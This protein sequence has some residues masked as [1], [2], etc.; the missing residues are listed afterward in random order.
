MKKKLAAP[1]ALA[2]ALAAA[3][4]AFGQG[5]YVG[6]GVGQG[7]VDFGAV[8]AGVTM[9]DKDTTATVRLGYQFHRSLAVE[10]GYYHL[11]DY[12]LAARVGGADISA[13]AEARSVGIAL[14]GTVPLNRFDL[15]GRV[16]YARSELKATGSALGFS[17]SERDRENEWFAGIG[18]RFHVS[19]EVGVFAEWQ[20]H[21]KLELDTFF[22]GVDVRF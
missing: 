20:R 14:V 5:W 10:I 13:G 8:P 3:A 4:P 6:A 17:A 15:Y 19:R 21:D 16:G 1:L 11:G 22:V 2:A 18:G 12:N 9:D 7:T